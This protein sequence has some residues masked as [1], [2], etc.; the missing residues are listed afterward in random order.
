MMFGSSYHTRATDRRPQRRSWPL[1]LVILALCWV[2]HS[3]ISVA[4]VGVVRYSTN[5]LPLIVPMEHL[6]QA[7]S[8]YP[9]LAVDA[10][11]DL[12][13]R[14]L[15]PV[16]GKLVGT[17]A[18]V[19]AIL[20]WVMNQ[21]PKTESWDAQSS[22]AMLQHGRSGGGL[23]C[24]GLAQVLKDALL[25]VG[26]PARTVTFQRNP[27]NFAETHVSVE[28]WVDGKWRLYD[29]TFHIALTSAGQRVGV[30]E[31]RNWFIK[32]RGQPVA[33]EFLGDVK[34]PARLETYPI[35]Y[36]I[37]FDNPYVNLRQDNAILDGIPVLKRLNR[38]MLAYSTDDPSLTNG[39]QDYYRV[40][41]YT[42]LVVLPAVNLM[43]LLAVIGSWMR[44]RRS[45]A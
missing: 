28:A 6:D 2:L 35:R 21:V 16:V 8:Y 44:V 36:E 13:R 39:A 32:G 40:L 42:T 14:E 26:V 30:A 31:A 22:W 10:E 3:I 20:K 5:G 18:K 7:G 29:P 41:Y 12:F 45:R 27:L 11:R 9:R 17:E 33:L 38:W 24:G 43:L 4:V 34:Y 25:A 1:P 15:E 23:I 37:F 19:L